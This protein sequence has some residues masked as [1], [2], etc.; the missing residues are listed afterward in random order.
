M[1]RAVSLPGVLGLLLVSALPGV[2]GDRP[3]PDLQAHPGAPARGGSGAAEPRRRPSPKDQ[4]ERARAEALP[5][6]L[7]YTAAVVAFVL[8]KC[9]QRK[10]E[11]AVLQEEA[12]KKEALQSG[13][14][15]RRLCA[16]GD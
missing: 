13:R 3:G 14:L 9:L 5:L 12:G 7:L 1:A 6:G 8:Y 16:G 2:L 15:G 4:R 10:E 11:A